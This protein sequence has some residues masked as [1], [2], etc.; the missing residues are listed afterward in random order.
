MQFSEQEIRAAL[1]SA[2]DNAAIMIEANALLV[3]RNHNR[4]SFIGPI[5]AVIV[6]GLLSVGAN[7]AVS[8]SNAKADLALEREKAEA[9]LIL[10]SFDEKDPGQTAKNLEFLV[11]ANLLPSSKYSGIADLAETYTPTTKTFSEPV[12]TQVQTLLLLGSDKTI[13]EAQHHKDRVIG[14]SNVIIIKNRSRFRT[15]LAFDNLEQAKSHLQTL[16]PEFRQTYEPYPVHL[17]EFCPNFSP[18]P[19]ENG[20]FFC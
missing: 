1:E 12:N 19:D 4:R 11:E 15:A 17:R 10:A 9:Q 18:L 6:G 13:E 20:V 7:L 2:P 8:N 16:S 3:E 5:Y 14:D